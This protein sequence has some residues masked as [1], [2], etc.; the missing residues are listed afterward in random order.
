MKTRRLIIGLALLAVGICAQLVL[1]TST[2]AAKP[3]TRFTVRIENISNADG[4][5][6]SDGRKW[7]FALSPGLFVLNE[8][9]PLFTE[10]RATKNGL[11]A[12]AED[13]NPAAL[14]ASLEN[15]HHAGAL[16]GVY[17]TPA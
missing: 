12:Q 5:V 15:M 6:A 13:G 10:G 1:S 17:N 11:E 16:H 3:G 9:N 7:P 8:K 14:V 2:R 4:Q